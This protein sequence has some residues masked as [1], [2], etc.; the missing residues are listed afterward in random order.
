[1]SKAAGAASRCITASAT[2]YSGEIT[3]SIGRW[4][5]R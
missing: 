2:A 5:L 1:M 4:S 3:T